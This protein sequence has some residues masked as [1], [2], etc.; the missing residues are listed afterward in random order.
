MNLKFTSACI[1]SIARFIIRTMIDNRDF[2]ADFFA[3]LFIF[4]FHHAIIVLIFHQ[5]I[6]SVSE[7]SDFRYQSDL[8]ENFQGTLWSK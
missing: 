8:F 5:I 1:T 6:T 7:T 2:A 4:S 3:N